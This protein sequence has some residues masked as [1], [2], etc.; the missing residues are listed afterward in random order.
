MRRARRTDS[1][2]AEIRA[3]FRRLCPAVADTSDVGRGFPDLVVLCR[4]R[5]LLVEVKDGSKPPS[6]RR[7]TPDEEGFARRWGDSYRVVTSVDEAIALATPEAGSTEYRTA[8]IPSLDGLKAFYMG[9]SR[10]R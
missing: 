4:G 2:H 7:L 10:R 6:A 8:H 5:V 3:V 1:N 9:P